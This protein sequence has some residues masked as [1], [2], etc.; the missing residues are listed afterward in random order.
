MK[1]NVTCIDCGEP[2]N[3]P[4]NTTIPF[5]GWVCQDCQIDAANEEA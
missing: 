2:E 3:V 5:D 4:I 1:M